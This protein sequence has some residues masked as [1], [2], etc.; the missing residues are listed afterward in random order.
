MADGGEERGSPYDYLFKM[1]LVGDSGVGKTCMLMR[2]VDGSFTESFIATIGIDFKVK[3][4]QHDGK[5]IKLQMWD[6]AGQE[7]F[8][9]IT[10]A[11]Y[12]GAMG[13]I[14]VYDISQAHTFD[15]IKQWIQNVKQNSSQHVEL[16]L[17][18]NKCDLE[19]DRK[20]PTEKAAKLAKEYEMHFFEVSAKKNVNIDEAFMKVVEGIHKKLKTGIIIAPSA[21]RRST[22]GS[23][24]GSQAAA[25]YVS[26]AT[27]DVSK[28]DKEEDGGCGC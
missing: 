2:Y 1:L 26:S 11:Y 4:V 24:A 10:T 18:G 17:V 28:K 27:V 20:V 8:K 5:N 7:R 6:T 19:A 25:E 23:G 9:S 14:M 12:R 3:T 13:Y 21:T 15:N 22:S 16:V